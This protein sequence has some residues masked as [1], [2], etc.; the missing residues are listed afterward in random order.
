M[1]LMA[2]LL[3]E[4]ESGVLSATV[5][6][7]IRTAQ[8]VASGRVKDRYHFQVSPATIRTTMAELE[9][10]GYLTHPHTSAGKVPT[11]KGYRAYVDDLMVVGSLNTEITTRI[12]QNLEQ[13]SGDIDKLLRIV[14]HIIS[15][16]SGGIGI[17]LAPVN[18][19]SRLSAVRLVPFNHRRMLFVLELHSGSVQTV[20][21]EW[22]K[23]LDE[24]Q[25]ILLEEILNERL[26]DLTLEEIQATIGQRLEGT[27]ADE[28]GITAFILDHSME[29]FT[30]RD[31]GDLYLF[32]LQQVLQSPE[33]DDQNNIATLLRLIE[34]ED[35]L[36]TIIC[37]ENR[38][39]DLS[40]TIGHEHRTEQME[41]FATISCGLYYGSSVG[42]MAV[43][44]P[45][46]VN[47]PHVIAVLDFL[48]K[49]ISELV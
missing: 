37:R 39:T 42:T 10:L 44:A 3:S 6:D 40:V 45:K 46:R 41:T 9:R 49:S 27:L 11:D 24:S 2:S 18:P 47:Y 48:S 7:Y 29:L 19:T 23:T 21:A 16:L 25:L 34:D 14:S 8:P 22:K 38:E 31:Q 26:S 36:R 33:F 15:Q 4:R 35:M 32:G 13:L 28:L 20:V 5:K 43:L 30:N 12:A 17:T 1:K